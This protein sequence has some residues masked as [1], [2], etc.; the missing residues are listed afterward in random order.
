MEM[1][2]GGWELR[3]RIL[4]TPITPPPPNIPG[5]ARATYVSTTF[6]AATTSH[7]HPLTPTNYQTAHTDTQTQTQTHSHTNTRHE[8]TDTQ[9]MGHLEPTNHSFTSPDPAHSYT[10]QACGLSPPLPPL[11][12]TDTYQHRDSYPHKHAGATARA[13]TQ[14]HT[15]R[16]TH[17]HT[18]AA[19]EKACKSSVQ[20][21]KSTLSGDF[22]P[23]N[24]LGH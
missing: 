22:Y 6:Y 18:P 4:A 13:H 15:H 20:I 14:T 9:A 12:H 8:H 2:E 17:T 21:L 7:N 11:S 1:A 3:P 24:I 10:H 19:L 16:E 23:V 5:Y